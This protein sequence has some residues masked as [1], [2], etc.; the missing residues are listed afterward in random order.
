MGG[1]ERKH[2]FNNKAFL[3]FL[4]TSDRTPSFFLEEERWY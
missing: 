1:R 4:F 3:S 2:D